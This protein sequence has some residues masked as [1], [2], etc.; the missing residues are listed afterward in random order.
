MGPRAGFSQVLIVGGFVLLVAIGVGI[1][2]GNHVLGQVA[3]QEPIAPTPVPIPTQ[4]SAESG[5]SAAWKHLTILSVATDPA[6][7]DPRITP[8]PEAV[9]TPRRTPSPKPSP[10]PTPGTGAPY[11]SPPLPVPFA[12]EGATPEAEVTGGSRPPNAGRTST[13]TRA[14]LPPVPVPSVNP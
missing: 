5:N 12:T 1:A 7:P 14:T 6:F 4:P 11:T 13:P 10:S 2:M 8:E 3:G 9:A